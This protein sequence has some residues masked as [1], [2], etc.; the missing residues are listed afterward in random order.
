MTALR[1]LSNETGPA[2]TA[3]ATRIRDACGDDEQAF[4]D[5]LDG[6]TDAVEAARRVVRWIAEQDAN[7]D[8][9]KALAETYAARRKV[10]EAR[11]ESARLA[12]L[13]FLNGIGQKRLALP[14]AT[15]TLST[16]RPTLLGEP[17]PEALPDHLVRVKREP[18][19]S[20]IVAE[21]AKGN[22]VPG[23][24]MSNAAPILQLRFK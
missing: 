6:E 24:V 4:I 17:D 5:T 22:T 15:V 7:A 3:L 23:C 14:E 2:L 16:S 18:N 21:L 9:C 8:A 12:L 11:I 19:R 10:F 1:A 13:H 20:A